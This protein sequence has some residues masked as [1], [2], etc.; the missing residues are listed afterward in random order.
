VG[1]ARRHPGA[2]SHEVSAATAFARAT[3]VMADHRWHQ[4]QIEDFVD[5]VAHGRRPLVDGREGMRSLDLVLAVYASAKAGAAVD[6]L[7]G[8]G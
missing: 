3:H 8:A 2:R 4:L 6:L 7:P 5:A 1:P